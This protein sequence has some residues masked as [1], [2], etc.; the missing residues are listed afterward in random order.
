MR[1]SSL[2]QGLPSPR[3]S[4]ADGR[5]KSPV[6]S[7]V[8]GRGLGR[9]QALRS[10][11]LAGTPRDRRADRDLRMPARGS[12]RRA[13]IPAAGAPKRVRCAPVETRALRAQVV[14]HGTVAPLPDRD[15]QI[16]PQVAGR[17]VEVLVREGDRVTRGQPLARIED[18]ALADQAK[19]AGA[20]VTK[21]AR[22]DQPGAHHARPGRTRRRPR[23]RRAPGAGRRA[24][25]ARDRAG[26]R[27]RGARRGRHRHAPARARHRAQPARGRGAQAVPQVRASWST[28]R[29][30]RRCWR[31]PTPPSSS[32]WRP[33]PPRIWSGSTRATRSR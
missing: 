25:A 20:Q 9:G 29:R 23:H 2:S 33:R 15:A 16:A 18:A 12:G 14:L 22:R 5:R 32:W 4:P 27:D 8:F 7:P 10:R 13:R 21:A 28:A 31:S 19:Q 24:G 11:A 30:R 6:P 3:P 17:I 1:R 26:R